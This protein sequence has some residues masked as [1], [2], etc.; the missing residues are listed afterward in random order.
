MALNATLFAQNTDRWPFPHKAC[1]DSQEKCVFTGIQQ[2]A[3]PRWISSLHAKEFLHLSLYFSSATHQ[4]Q[5]WGISTKL[6]LADG[7][8]DP[9]GTLRVRKAALSVHF[10][11]T[12]GVS[13]LQGME[14]VRW[15]RTSRP[16]SKPPED[17]AWEKT[18]AN[19][20]SGH[21]CHLSV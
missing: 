10:T 6:H 3:K 16:I 15:L 14:F 17:P 20:L 18:V 7:A 2:K 8:P 12:E 11:D 19:G 13:N 5:D 4:L 1:S 9:V 21:Y